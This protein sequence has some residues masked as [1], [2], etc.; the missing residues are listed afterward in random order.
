MVFSMWLSAWMV[1]CGTEVGNPEGDVPVL[2]NARSQLPDVSLEPSAS[3]TTVTAVWLR[4]D[5]VA[6]TTCK[7]VGSQSVALDPLGLA[8][9]AGD[10]AF[11]QVATVQDGPWCSL[12]TA[13]VPGETGPTEL[14]RG[15]SMVLEGELVDGRSFAIVVDEPIGLALHLDEPVRPEEG[16]WLLSFDV[17][18]WIDPEELTAATDDPVIVS[19]TEHT[20]VYDA[21]VSRLPDGV[22]LHHDR[23]ADGVV[24]EGDRRLD[25]R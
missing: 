6:L 15:A 4:L 17:G 14:T 16:A 22:T 12:V 3:T 23:E 21:V 11:E 19:A 9:H 13:L 18:A 20:G 1:G 10:E 5:A 24:D 7:S 25:L 8:D 2:Y